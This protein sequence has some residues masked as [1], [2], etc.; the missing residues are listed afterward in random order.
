MNAL[1]TWRKAKNISLESMASTLGVSA[2][3]LSR[4]ERGEQWP[5]RETFAKVADATNG[6]VTANDFLPGSP[7]PLVQACEG[8]APTP[9]TPEKEVA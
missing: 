7:S 4:I 1:R 5:S 9:P 8:E 6:E 2:G 3:S